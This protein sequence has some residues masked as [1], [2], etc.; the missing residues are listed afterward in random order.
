MPKQIA[1]EVLGGTVDLTQ[2]LQSEREFHESEDKARM[3][4]ALIS[5]VYSSGFF[6]EAEACLYD[7][8][9]D[10]EG[11]RTLDYGCGCGWTTR[12]LCHRGARVIGFDI[13][14]TRLAEAQTHL[15]SRG[16]TPPVGL[17][18]CAAERL[19][20]PDRSFEAILG[21]GIL[22]HLE[23]S[24]ALPEIVRVLGPAGK[25]AFLEPL[26]HNPFLELYRRLTPGLRSPDERALSISDL[27]AIGSH[28]DRWTYKCFCLLAIAPA[29]LES[30]IPR[31]KVL[32]SMRQWLQR[33]DRKMVDTIP[34]VGR[35]CW[36]AV[37]VL[38]QSGD[39]Q[40]QSPPPAPSC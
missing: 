6:E 14:Q 12:K 16:S 26:V 5:G 23:L 4:N 39:E 19:P 9:G 2:R 8:L 27:E 34:F 32:T 31:A 20:F 28:F 18:L 30:L 33:V 35:Y 29:L 13:S 40:S 21:K 10:L 38:E 22:H 36:E 7:S 24:C 1:W 25:A 37:I 3:S 17:V 15:F 11:M